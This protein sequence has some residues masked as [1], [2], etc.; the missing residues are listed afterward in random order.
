MST[1]PTNLSRAPNILTA[2]GALSTI[3]R[4]NVALF[5]AQEQLATGRAVNRFSDDAV[6]A[7]A[8]SIL[9]DRLARSAQRLRNFQHADAALSTL[10][11]A[12]GSANDLVLDAKEIA[13]AQ[14]GV[15]SSPDERTA[16]ARVVE[17]L[18]QNLFGI[19]NRSGVSG[20][21]FGGSDPTHAPVESLLGG[22]RYRA[23][24]EGLFTDLDMGTSVP[25][26]L[27][28]S[29]IGSTSSRIQG[30]AD[31]NPDLTGASRLSDLAGARGL[32]VSLGA[33]E[34]SFDGGARTRVDLSGAQ[35]A[36]DIA[37][38]I[39]ASIRDY[40]TANSVTILGAG[41]VSFSGGS[42]RIDVAAGPPDPELEFF[43][44]STGITAQDLGLT[45]APFSATSALGADLGPR[46]TWTTPISALAGLTGPLGQIRVKSLGQ[47]RTVDLSSAQ[48]LE[49]VKNLIES[50]GV[51]L[52]VEI[53]AAGD[54]INILNEVAAGIAQ[55]LSIEEIA[56][57]GLTATRLGI[58]SLSGETRIADFND[59]RGV[60]IV[61]GGADPISGQPDP[62]R[63]VDFEINLG[64]GTTF[65]VDLRPQDMTTVQSVIDRINQQAA[66]AGIAVPATFEARLSD[67]PNGFVLAQDPSFT[68]AIT[69]S[70]ENNSL[71]A[72]QLGL[73]NL[74]SDG[75]G[76]YRS[77]DRA[78]VRV[79]NLFTQLI[80]LRD[81]L[82][83]NDTI[84]I[85]LAG[86]RLEAATDRIAQ[87]RATV[88]SYAQR[89]ED[90]TRQ[91]E[92]QDLMD[93]KSRSTLRDLDYTEAAVRLNLLQMQLQAGYQV[94]S[95]SFSRSLLDFLG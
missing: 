21:I 1:I 37:D 61:T 52:R 36:Q 92:D 71:A 93:E 15:G 87:T 46:L 51:G 38:R 9:D 3:T 33:I 58:R 5:R 14:V 68:G 13:S 67:G 29:A 19:S 30:S 31:L 64:D 89:V 62:T 90:G 70:G 12:L 80:D 34:F 73:S 65:T 53:N 91:L 81:A 69:V 59:G 45:T 76:A 2:Q 23:H 82:L 86:E 43:D 22:Y 56:G 16:Q 57:N 18:I 75:A 7:A 88:G 94:T 20:Y 40:E 72:D 84:G 42:L 44:I 27:G 8:I 74:T 79:D 39:T 77:E 63:D 78:R 66:D 10:D 47:S 60:Q 28:G 32:G 85:T 24:G 54:G 35:T 48:T 6:K 41:G 17:S 95:Q 11:Q 49:D 25:V 55:A 83:N 50:T 26:T 4:T